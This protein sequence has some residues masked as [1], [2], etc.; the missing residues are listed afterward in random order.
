MGAKKRQKMVKRIGAEWHWKAILMADKL[1]SET[2]FICN[3]IIY[4]Y[5]FL[6][7]RIYFDLFCHKDKICVHSI[8][9]HWPQKIIGLLFHL[10][11][12][13]LF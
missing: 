3:Y 9:Y 4:I 8:L 10:I 12:H 13:H 11:L 6:F 1:L 2:N 5:I 7:Y